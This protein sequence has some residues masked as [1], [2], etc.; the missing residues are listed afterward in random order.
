MGSWCSWREEKDSGSLL[1]KPYKRDFKARNGTRLDHFFPLGLE[2]SSA[3][4]SQ[5]SSHPEKVQ[6]RIRSLGWRSPETQNDQ[7]QEGH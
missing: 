4:C 5:D 3:S 6:A 1:P 7:G 2:K